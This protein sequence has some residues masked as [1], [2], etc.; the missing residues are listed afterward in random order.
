MSR[1]VGLVLALLLLSGC[2]RRSPRGVAE[3]Y[4]EDLQQFNYRACYALLSEQ[5]RKERSFSE[6]LTEIPLAPDVSPV[7]FRPIL[8]DTHYQLGAEQRSPDGR[9]ATVAVQIATP[10]L[11]RWERALD[12]SSGGQVSDSAVQRSLELGNYPVWSYTDT[13]FLLKERHHWRIRAGF[14]ARDQVIDRHRTALSD[15][16][17]QHYDKAIPQ[18]RDMIAELDKQG[19]TGSRGLAGLYRRELARIQQLSDAQPRARAY[20]TRLSLSGVAMKM[21]EQRLPAIFGSVKN[22]GDRAVDSLSLA[23]SWYVGRGKELKPIA[24]EVHSIIT[25]PVEFTDF[26]QPVI[27]FLPGQARSFGFLLTAPVPVQQKAS[28]Y[29]SI[30]SIALSETPSIPAN[31]LTARPSQPSSP[32]P[33]DT[34]TSKAVGH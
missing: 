33:R 34:P 19:S 28:P 7:W 12:A 26:T 11:T 14:A 2:A 10:D 15:Y 24:R 25:T 21:S 1:Q 27:P 29:V 5:D 6:F 3:R 9:A 23:V 30:D 4:L 20:S 16:I 31:I 32:S 8:H 17:E 18:W 13:I 22:D